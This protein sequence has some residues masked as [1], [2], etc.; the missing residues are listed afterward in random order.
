[1]STY[2]NTVEVVKEVVTI[3]EE[4]PIFDKVSVEKVTPLSEE[5][6][7]A[8]VYVGVKAISY[9]NA[10]ASSGSCGYNRSLFITLDI[11]LHCDESPLELLEIVDKTERTVLGDSKLWEVII[12]RDMVGVEFD[13]LQFYPRR[14]ATMLLEIT[15]KISDE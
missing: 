4:S 12:N 10:R 1:M 11:N 13:E 9:E 2:L 6:V 14:T 8:A 15:Y 3:L 5:D 7:N